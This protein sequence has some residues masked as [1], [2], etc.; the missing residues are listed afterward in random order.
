MEA[1]NGKDILDF[2]EINLRLEEEKDY[3]IVEELTR[4]AFWNVYFP[5]CGEHLLVHNLRKATEFIKE[6]DFVAI[7]NNKLIGN[8]V[9]VKA[10]IK[11]MDKEYTVLT[12]GP[13]SVSPEYQ[14]NGI[15]STLIKHTINLAKE[16]GYRAI[17]IYGDP[18]YYKRFGF[19]ESKEYTITN[20]DK[21]Y[22]A[23]LLV[24]ELYPN[25][26]N[27]IKGIFDEGKSYEID[28]K[29]LEEFE[30]GFNKKEKG[31][32]KT[33]DRFNELVNKYL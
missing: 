29:E 17:I 15:G 30:K 9:Y 19:K 16:L 28:E 8:I 14:N 33:Q 11:N 31:F 20:K 12:F 7:Y 32:A 21:K 23:A 13:L 25:A 10:K 2:M 1:K 3:R 4:E 18:E 22:P 27:G 5:G 6:L 24:L 26:L